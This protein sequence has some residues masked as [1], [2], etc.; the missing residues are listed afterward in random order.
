MSAHVFVRRLAAAALVVWAIAATVSGQT[1]HVSPLSIQITSPL[2]RTGISG[3][4]RIV[5]RIVSAPGSTLSKVTFYVDGKLVGEDADGPPY[6]VEWVDENPF[7]AREITVQVADSLGNAAKDS[8]DLKPLQINETTSVSAVL[9]EP[10]VLD[11]K[12]RSVKGLTAKDFQL[13]EDNIPQTL[14]QAIPDPI[15]ATYTLLID[16]SQSMSR[17]MDFV[18]DAAREFPL[19]LRPKDD[20]M[21]VPFTKSLGVVTGPTQ[22]RDTITG[23]IDAIDAKGGT[24]ILDCLASVARQLKQVPSRHVIV[25]IT[26]G[27]DEDSGTAFDKSLAAIKADGSTVFV[28]AIGGVA[29]ISL[30][31]EDLLR[32]IATET[33]GRA[34]FPLRERQRAVLGERGVDAADAGEQ[35][36]V[37][38]RVADLVGLELVGRD[39]HDAV[40]AFDAG[41]QDA[42][43]QLGRRDPHHLPG[44]R[45]EEADH[46]DGFVASAVAAAA[47]L[48]PVSY[49]H[50]VPCPN[51]PA[52]RGRRNDARVSGFRSAA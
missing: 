13:V 7:E 29:G 3:A 20:V 34:F 45:V 37:E 11:P 32:R 5:A 10:L 38:G 36:A 9:V 18:R 42:R 21:V 12:G 50:R 24:A 35:V 27:Y 1:P 23:A 8:V 4:V 14:Q 15:P 43:P 40:D 31:G 44:R 6:A 25:L 16:A 19:H 47:T 33:G 46:L 51:V 2:G 48:V 30:Q 22:D 28:V 41:L 17:R 52:T 49:S 39:P 26:D